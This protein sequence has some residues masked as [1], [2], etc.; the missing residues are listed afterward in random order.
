MLYFES[1]TDFDIASLS[2]CNYALLSEG[3]PII[4]PRLPSVFYMHVQIFN[5]VFTWE[6]PMPMPMLRAQPDSFTHA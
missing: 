3:T 2:R 1:L 6:L 5:Q 4:H